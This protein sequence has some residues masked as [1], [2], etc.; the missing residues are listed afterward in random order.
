MKKPDSI[1]GKR[2]LVNDATSIIPPEKPSPKSMVLSVI[3]LPRITGTAPMDVRMAGI[4]PMIINLY[5]SG[6]VFSQAMRSSS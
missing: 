4:A 5:I 2:R 6:R 1:A 3:L